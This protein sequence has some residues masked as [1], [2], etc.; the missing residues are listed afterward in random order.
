MAF[1]SIFLIFLSLIRLTIEKGARNTTA[2]IPLKALTVYG[3]IY[4]EQDD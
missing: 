2:I 4:L 1:L 3:P